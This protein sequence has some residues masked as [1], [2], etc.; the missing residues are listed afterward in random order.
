MATQ[1]SPPREKPGP[2]PS[3]GEFLGRLLA[4]GV[5]GAGAGMLAGGLGLESWVWVMLVGFAGAAAGVL[6]AAM[7]TEREP[8]EEWDR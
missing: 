6:G 2:T 7:S 8:P 1:L 3:A 4:G 5:L